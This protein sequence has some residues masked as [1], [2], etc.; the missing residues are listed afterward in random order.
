MASAPVSLRGI[1]RERWRAIT[2]TD[3][4]GHQIAAVRKDLSTEYQA[5]INVPKKASA[6]RNALLVPKNF[7][8]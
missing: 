4:D 8:K 1:I 2:V 7:V 5:Q 6:P 3:C